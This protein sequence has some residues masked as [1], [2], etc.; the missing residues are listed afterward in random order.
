MHSFLMD[1]LFVDS[2]ETVT[3]I[4]HGLP[5]ALPYGIFIQ[6]V[7]LLVYFVQRIFLNGGMA[8]VCKG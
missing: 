7:N 5:V 6:S 2:I 8:G 3:L 1:N 4:T